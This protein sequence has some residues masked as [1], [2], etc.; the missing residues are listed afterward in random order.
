MEQK[1]YWGFLR[2]QFV[3]LETTVKIRP[4]LQSDT[5]N[6]KRRRKYLPFAFTKQGVA[7][8]SAVLR[9]ETA[10]NVSI[11]IMNAFIIY[12]DF[13]CRI[14][15]ELATIFQLHTTIFVIATLWVNRRNC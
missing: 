15:I 2:S 8:L 5:D 12:A 9:S 13:A 3:T 1:Y 10:M 11:G 14:F 6:C 4:G 7:V